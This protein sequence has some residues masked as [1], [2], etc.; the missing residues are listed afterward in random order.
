M[1]KWLNLQSKSNSYLSPAVCVIGENFVGESKKVFQG[2]SF[3]DLLAVYKKGILTWYIPQKNMDKLFVHVFNFVKNNPEYLEEV[4]RKLL[5]D[6]W[7]FKIFYLSLS[8][9]D[10]SKLSNKKL[11]KLYEKYQKK[12]NFLYTWGE[13][14]AWVTKDTLYS[15]LLKYL[16]KQIKKESLDYSPED[17][18][19]KLSLSPEIS[20]IKKEE[21]ELVKLALFIQHNKKFNNL[22]KKSKREINKFLL[23]N[24]FKELNKKID[25]HIKKYCWIPYDYG[26]LLWNKEYFIQELKKLLKNNNL[27]NKFKELEN[28]PQKLKKEQ[29]ELIQKIKIDKKKQRILKAVRICE[30]LMDYKKE[31]FTQSHYCIL[32]L[33]QEIAQR[34]KLSLL[35]SRFLMPQEIKE[36]LFNNKIFKE[37][38]IKERFLFSIFY[39]KENNKMRLLKYLEAKMLYKEILETNRFNSDFTEIKGIVANNGFYR[40][41]VKIILDAKNTSKMKKGEILI[42][43]MTSPDYLSA[44]KKSGAIITNEGGI[45]CHA[46]IIARELKKPCIIGTKIATQV[47]KDGDEVIVDANQG[48][49]RRLDK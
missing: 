7:S 26:A 19:G 12:Y 6:S 41:K 39:F 15:Y 3:G 22:F 37:K 29:R 31:I 16:K 1:L 43:N 10:Y 11:W 47:L 2:L 14:I 42:T 27:Q 32:P 49:V 8:D 44:V 17:C 18:L 25:Q 36:A 23:K 5:R 24:N 46:T 45:T 48:I 20:F 4:K 33:L 30:F 40:G 34:I 28:Y 13:P 35:S 9:K 21:I 38:Q